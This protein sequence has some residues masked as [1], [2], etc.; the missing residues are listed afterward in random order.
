MN[1]DQSVLKMIENKLNDLRYENH[2]LEKQIEK[3]KK[4]IQSLEAAKEDIL[5][6]QQNE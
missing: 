3:N 4:E 2:Y 6:R 1:L 5:N